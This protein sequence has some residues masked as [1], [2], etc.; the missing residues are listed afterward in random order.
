MKKLILGLFA[1]L[2]MGSTM[3]QTTIDFDTA[4]NW[5][6]GS[7]SLSSYAVDHSY[8]QGNFSSVAW[9]ALRNSNAVQGS[10]PGALGDYSWRL[11]NVDT[12]Q[13][14][15]TIATGGVSAF[16]FEARAWDNSPSP[17]YTLESSTDLGVSWDSITA[18]NNTTLG[19]T[20]AWT[21]FNGVIN[22]ANNN[23]MVRIRANGPTE[24]IMIDNFTWSPFGATLDTIA[25]ITS[26]DMNV[27]ENVGTVDITIELNQPA[28]NTTSLDLVIGAAT[29]GTP[30]VISN[31]TSSAVTFAPGSTSEMVTIT[32]ASGQMASATELFVFEI[33]NPSSDLVLGTDTEFQLTVN[34]LP[35][36]P[37]PCDDLFFS[38]YIESTGSKAIEIYN[39]TTNII[40]LTTYEVRRYSNGASTPTATLALFGSLVPG[41]VFVISNST[42]DQAVLD[43]ADLTTGFMSHNGDDAL[44][45]FNTSSG[46]SLDIIGEIGV[47]PGSAW[48]VG[49]GSTEDVTMVR[50][51]TI[52]AGNLLWIG[53]S[54]QEWDVYGTNEYSFLGA[55][56]NTSCS[57]PA[58]PT[59]Y[60]N[61]G[62][63]YCLGET[64]ELTHNSFGGATPY[65]VQWDID[66]NIS[67]TDTV[68]FTPLAAG[69]VNVTLTITD[70]NSAVDDSVFT[71]T[72]N[73]PPSPGFTVSN[74]NICAGDTAFISSTAT[75]SG[76][77]TH[78][79]SVAPTATLN[80]T[81]AGSGY[82][83]TLTDGVYVITQDIVD[84]AGCMA[85]TNMTVNVNMLDD[86]S[87]TPLSDLCDYETIT[88]T[89]SNTTGTWS[90]T[91][92]TDNGGGMG[93][94]SSATAGTFE[95]T[96]TTSGACPAAMTDTVDV[97]ASPVADFNFSGGITVNFSDASTGSV[98][99]YAWDFGDGNTATS[100]NPTHTYTT[101]GTYTACLTVT[102]NEGCEDVICKT[103]TIAGVGIEQSNIESFAV[104]PNPTSGIVQIK[105]SSNGNLSVI[106]LIGEIIYHS[107]IRANQTLDLSHLNK[108]TY[109]VQ[110][111]SNG[112]VTT[113]KLI[114]K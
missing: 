101:D 31:F 111:E 87:F 50:M 63:E 53:G 62:A 37:A 25:T 108:G 112:Q 14:V 89:H 52:G 103:V 65:S 11:R 88:L 70:N 114:I 105:T 106:N 36:G 38:E 96:Y 22:S 44:E 21:T 68:Q 15:G 45:L 6:P 41:E 79:Y 5:I 99:T 16:S 113:E 18:I 3:A 110:F 47:D 60:P 51:A 34:Q 107:T 28:M 64:I 91:G 8:V 39:P 43:A 27:M 12:S 92:V 4:A 85:S 86:A 23:I 98:M 73:T 109:F 83:T 67:T 20:D 59:A 90:G 35:T 102:N 84:F 57:G 26:M 75:G 17:D 61:V 19:N 7:A 42:A 1:L 82:F 93:E 100:A 71:I 48:T 13:W 29:T 40:D 72:I 95:I 2:S 56:T 24:R 10:T 94:F 9:P 30:A 55:H 49:T 46:S 32:I 74:A 104:Y 77:I 33:T 54:D 80:T 81:I 76:V 66:G 78:S 97:F 69:T 58:T